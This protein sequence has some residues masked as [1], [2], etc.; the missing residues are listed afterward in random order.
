LCSR[1]FIRFCMETRRSLMNL[2]VRFPVAARPRVKELRSAVFK[3]EQQVEQTRVH[4]FA[5]RRSFRPRERWLCWWGVASVYRRVSLHFNF[6][7]V[8]SNL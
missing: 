1:N 8:N 3:I 6:F 2:Q 4:M 5:V 7:C